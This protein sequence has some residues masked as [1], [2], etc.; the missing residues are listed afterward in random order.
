MRDTMRVVSLTL[1]D[2]TIFRLDK[3]CTM[4][5]TELG[6]VISRSAMV[7]MLINKQE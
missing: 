3:L 7:R 4:K 1:D 2:N 6:T 5:S